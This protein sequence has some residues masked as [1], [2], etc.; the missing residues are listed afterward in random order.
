MDG[1]HKKECRSL[2]YPLSDILA[3]YNGTIYVNLRAVGCYV[4]YY[5]VEEGLPDLRGYSKTLVKGEIAL[6]TS[7]SVGLSSSHILALTT[8]FKG[9]PEACLISAKENRVVKMHWLT[10]PSKI[11]LVK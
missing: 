1:T 4:R 3:T 8:Q 7:F 6:D 9:I 5:G 2:K 10:V 11:A